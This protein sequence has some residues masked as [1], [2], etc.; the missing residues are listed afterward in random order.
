MNCGLN[1]S[2]TSNAVQTVWPAF[3]VL[4]RD[5]KTRALRVRPQ[6]VRFATHREKLADHF[7]VASRRRSVDHRN[8]AGGHIAG[9]AVIH[10]RQAD[11]DSLAASI[12]DELNMV[13]PRVLTQSN[14]IHR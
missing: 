10:S 5:I 6:P 7:A 3:G 2:E 9:S 14:R 8:T 13:R 4:V 12:L 11:V 1:G